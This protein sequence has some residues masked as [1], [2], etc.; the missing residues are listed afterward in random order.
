MDE[1]EIS[2]AG[3]S[4][5]LRLQLKYISDLI[6]YSSDELRERG[7]DERTIEELRR[8]LD[9]CD[10]AL[11]GE[12]PRP[13]PASY[14]CPFLIGASRPDDENGLD[15]ELDVDRMLSADSAGAT[16]VPPHL[17]ADDLPHFQDIDSILTA[18]QDT[19]PHVGSATDPSDVD[20]S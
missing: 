10:L 13:V 18:I 1:L 17:D 11:R 20:D 12:T 9:W 8:I 15:D 14:M 7:A 6:T 4:L 3:G 2:V 5:F 19:D 16:G